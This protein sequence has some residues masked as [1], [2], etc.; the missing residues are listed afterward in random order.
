MGG[1]RQVSRDRGGGVIRVPASQRGHRPVMLDV[2]KVRRV[3]FQTV[4]QGPHPKP[5]A[6][7]KPK[8]YWPFG[9]SIDREVKFAVQS[10]IVGWRGAGRCIIQAAL[11]TSRSVALAAS[12]TCPPGPI[13]TP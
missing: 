10:K 13:T 4:E 3:G 9:R 5:G 6:L 2:G 1:A 11:A 7:D 8:E 12:S